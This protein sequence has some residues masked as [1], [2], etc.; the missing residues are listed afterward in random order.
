MKDVMLR[1]LATKAARKSAPAT[2]GV[3]KLY[4]YRPGNSRS[5]RDPPIPEIHRAVD[6]R[7]ALPVICGRNRLRFQDICVSRAQ[8]LW[9]FGKQ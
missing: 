1:Q 5:S 9:R 8:L 7:A 4:H 6:P 2:G 3:K